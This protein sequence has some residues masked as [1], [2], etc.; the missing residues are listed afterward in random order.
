MGGFLLIKVI[1]I[2]RRN[3][4]WKNLGQNIKM[5]IVL[6]RAGKTIF[7]LESGLFVQKLIFLMNNFKEKTEKE[8]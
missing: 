8:C 2:I 7:R 1:I 4:G 5:C 3:G 6:I